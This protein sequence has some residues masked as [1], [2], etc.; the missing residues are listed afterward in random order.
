M[1]G[2]SDFRGTAEQNIYLKNMAERLTE[3]DIE[4]ILFDEDEIAVMD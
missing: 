1:T 3:E 4:A 2:Q